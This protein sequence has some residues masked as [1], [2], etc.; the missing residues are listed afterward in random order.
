MSEDESDVE[1]HRSK[2][3][4]TKKM[5]EVER[6]AE[7]ER[8]RR[9]KEAEQKVAYLYETFLFSFKRNS[10]TQRNVFLKEFGTYSIGLVC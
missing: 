3:K 7:M 1:Q 9:Q 4:R 5:T 10:G 2:S 8:Q 6:L